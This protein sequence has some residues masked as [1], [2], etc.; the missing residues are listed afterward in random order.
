MTSSEQVELLLNPTMTIIYN[1]PA[2]VSKEALLKLFYWQEIPGEWHE[3]GALCGTASVIKQTP[4]PT[5]IR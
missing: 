4:L 1:E 2:D 3:V 5:N